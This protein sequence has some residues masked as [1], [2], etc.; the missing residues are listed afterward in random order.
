MGKAGMGM[1]GLRRQRYLIV[2]EV[3]CARG[4]AHGEGL[5]EGHIVGEDLL[6]AEVIFVRNDLVHVIIRHEE[7][8]SRVR[9]AWCTVKYTQVSLCRLPCLGTKVMSPRK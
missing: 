9:M 5:E 3:Y 1:E 6:V 7:I 4:E 2:K 8:C